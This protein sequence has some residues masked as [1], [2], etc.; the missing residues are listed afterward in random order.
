M[1]A[2]FL[3][4]ADCH[5]GYRQYNL[6]ERFNDFGR[7]FFGAINT[8]IDE[9]VDFV[10]LAGDL[11]HKRAID[12]LTLNQAVV[13][14]D[15]LKQ[16]GIPCIA[17]EGNHEHAYV[18]DFIGWM[19]F[20]ALREYLV[21]LDADFKEG[22]P[23]LK[24]Y[25]R[26]V[27]S[28]I[29]P[30]Q[31]LRVHGLRY[32]GAGTRTAVANYAKALADLTQDGVEFTVFMTHAGIE[33]EVAEQ[34]GGLSMGDWSPLRN[35]CDYVALG[36]IHK[37]FVRENWIHNPGSLE[38]CSA[39]EVSWADRGFLL[40]DVDTSRRDKIKH[41]AALRACTRRKFVRLNFKTDLIEDPDML[42]S[43]LQE[44][45]TRRARDLG[46][47]RLGADER[48]V[49]DLQLYGVL[50]FDRSALSIDHIT[51]MIEQIYEP[52]HTMVRNQTRSNDLAIEA[53]ESV[54]RRQ[55]E[56]RV[57]A[58][59]F[60]RDARYRAR[61]EQWAQAAIS[62]KNL[63]A[64]SAAPDAILDELTGYMARIEHGGALDGDTDS[65]ETGTETDSAETGDHAREME[66]ER[67]D[68]AD[69]VG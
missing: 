30:V 13:A 68:D 21:L 52:L 5:L 28:Y 18:D 41:T 34:M 55:L 65:T 35:H 54:N 25:A 9:K 63:A 31:G 15:R 64:D 43:Q 61:S 56:R 8:A 49:V 39:V 32:M 1:K 57:L 29:E 2:R 27:G 20:L 48:P 17:V 19:K 36:H 10:L 7:A 12:A 67:A 37:P 42:Y 40:V 59:L 14:L 16:A 45:L 46:I 22:Q 24:P 38:T 3:H 50:Q 47:A 58:D 51:Q 23:Q 53:G 60:G 66:S 33:G 6:R 44:L 62:I 4:I 69:S 26:R 11:F